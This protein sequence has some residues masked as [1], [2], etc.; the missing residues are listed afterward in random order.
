[1]PVHAIPG[2]SSLIEVDPATDQQVKTCTRCKVKQPISEFY[3]RSD[4]PD[5]LS[6]SCLSCV[7]G[8][9]VRLRVRWHFRTREE[10]EQ[11]IDAALMQIA[12]SYSDDK[13][14][15]NLKKLF[16]LNKHMAMTTINM[17]RRILR[18]KYAPRKRNGL[19]DTAAL[20]IDAIA[21][22]DAIIG[23]PN[24]KHTDIIAAQTRKDKILGLETIRIEAEVKTTVKTDVTIR[25]IVEIAKQNDTVRDLAIQ[26]ARAIPA[27]L[28]AAINQ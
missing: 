27:A 10:R 16:G 9:D 25:N 28:G 23:D 7:K 22:Y 2:D 15:R 1:M 12:K 11:H 26:M 20:V 18:E 21:V 13:I 8:K 6:T 5:G 14:R 17:A 4:R 24:A 19:P 3:A